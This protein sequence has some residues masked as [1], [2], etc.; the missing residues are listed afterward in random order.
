[1]LRVQQNGIPSLKLTCTGYCRYDGLY[2]VC[3]V[4]DSDGNVT[5]VTPIGNE[6]YTFQL[7]R[8]PI[9]GICG[10]N[11]YWNQV[12]IC[13]LCNKIG[14][15]K[16]CGVVKPLPKPDYHSL[17][18]LS[19]ESKGSGLKLQPRSHVKPYR[20]PNP[21]HLPDLL[22]NEAD[23]YCTKSSLAYHQF[24]EQMRLEQYY[25]ACHYT[26]VLSS[27]MPIFDP[28]HSGYIQHDLN[29]GLPM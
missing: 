23:R 12:S 15:S 27:Q 13:E 10:E 20:E 18:G 16:P 28:Y 8:L 3:R 11:K 4:F 21:L 1:M 24:S 2:S 19:N 9:Q 14:A 25:Q 6:Q 26:N 29:R 22:L 7:T 17:P 5:E